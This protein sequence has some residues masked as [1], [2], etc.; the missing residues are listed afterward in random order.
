MIYVDPLNDVGFKIMF[1][2]KNGKVNMLNF[3]KAI[4]PDLGIEDLEYLDT[5]QTGVTPDERRAV[6][7]LS[8]LLNDGTRVTVEMQRENLPYFNYRSVYYS[9]HVIQSQA[10]RERERQRRECEERGKVRMWDYHYQPVYMIGIL[11]KGM[12]RESNNGSYLE[13]YRILETSSHRD[14]NVDLNYIYLRLDRFEKSESECSGI[15]DMFAYSLKNMRELRRMPGTF[16]EASEMVEFYQSGHYASLPYE[17]THEIETHRNMTTE[18]DMLVAAKQDGIEIGRA[19]GLA[20]GQRESARNFKT[21][22]V[23][24]EII[25]KATGLSKEQV[26]AL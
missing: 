4:L 11:E 17:I 26:E 2:P 10:S 22:G 18:N 19:D 8:V 23:D 3:L 12:G 20:E 7:D 13:R 14:L 15:V 6:F 25:C 9:T 1:G 5:E 16:R 24:I 21:L